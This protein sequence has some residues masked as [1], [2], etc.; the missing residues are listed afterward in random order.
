MDRKGATGR[1]WAV[2]N[3]SAA[4]SSGHPPRLSLLLAPEVGVGL[5]ART[6]LIGGRVALAWLASPR[7]ALETLAS[8]RGGTLDG[9]GATFSHAFLG[10]G[11]VFRSLVPARSGWGGSLHLD[12]GVVRHAVTHLDEDDASPVHR[13]LLLP[14]ARLG[15]QGDW[16]FSPSTAV[17]AG[18]DLEA[19]AGDIDIYVNEIQRAKLG[20]F[21]ALAAV[22]LLIRY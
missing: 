17:F 3:R 5:G 4:E 8:Y 10:A 18:L 1:G 16:W 15:A 21:A 9:A 20:G 2:D 19:D 22:G 11:V 12:V 6:A 13:S 14:G 7:W